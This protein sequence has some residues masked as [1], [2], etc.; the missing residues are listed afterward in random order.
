[1]QAFIASE[2]SGNNDDLAIWIVS[3]GFGIVILKILIFLF[4]KRKRRN[5]LAKLAN[6]MGFSFSKYEKLPE[7]LKS[8]NL[9]LKAR[10]PSISNCLRGT[11]HNFP[12]TVV[13]FKYSTRGSFHNSGRSKSKT[14]RQT[15]AVI[16]LEERKV[17]A[18]EIFPES[19]FQKLKSAIGS[20]DID[21]ASHP[22]CSNKY[23]VQG[24]EEDAIRESL[25]VSFLTSIQKHRG[26]SIECDGQKIIFY[27]HKEI[28]SADEIKPFA[29]WGIRRLRELG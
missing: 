11:L 22:D 18:F 16:D 10:S 13:D 5:E 2:S 28:L 12:I 17:P 1:M 4:L 8:L 14:H 29:E 25:S 26:L 3:A 6:K 15:V 27:K 20:Q 21:F 24:S 9:F 23:V 19:I 7:S